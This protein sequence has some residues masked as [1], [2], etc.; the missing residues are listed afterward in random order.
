[1]TL[2]IHKTE[3]GGV[4]VDWDG[5]KAKIDALFGRASK[6]RAFI[7]RHWENDHVKTCCQ[8]LLTMIAAG[9]F[10]SGS[11]IL[12]VLF[13]FAA[14]VVAAQRTKGHCCSCGRTE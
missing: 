14:L 7:E 10:L 12:F 11:F 8:N 3:L 4:A 1:M 13:A 2:A 6:I 9:A 5:V